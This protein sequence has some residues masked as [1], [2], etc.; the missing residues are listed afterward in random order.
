MIDDHTL[1]CFFLD[2]PNLEAPLTFYSPG[3]ASLST[4][5]SITMSGLLYIPLSYSNEPA[6]CSHTAHTGGSQHPILFSISLTPLLQK[7]NYHD[8]DHKCLD[9][10]VV[11][12]KEERQ[13]AV[14]LDDGTNTGI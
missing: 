5:L 1:I 9:K 11:L 8:V 4:L 6:S 13:V 14:C 10:H 3:S 12:V 7:D 2:S